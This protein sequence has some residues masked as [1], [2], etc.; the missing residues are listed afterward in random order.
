MDTDVGIDP[1]RVGELP[2]GMAVVPN[3]KDAGY[4]VVWVV[5]TLNNSL[6][7]ITTNGHKSLGAFDH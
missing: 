7:R 4:Y 6:S 3:F 5:N 2:D 1:V